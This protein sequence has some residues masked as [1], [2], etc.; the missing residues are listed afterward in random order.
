MPE[1]VRDEIGLEVAGRVGDTPTH[2]RHGDTS[3]HATLSEC[4]HSVYS[5]GYATTPEIIEVAS[6]MFLVVD[7]F[8]DQLKIDPT[9]Q[10]QPRA[11]RVH[12]LPRNV[13]ALS[14]EQC[15][16]EF[17]ERRCDHYLFGW[18]HHVQVKPLSTGHVAFL[19][20]TCGSTV[21]FWPPAPSGR[22]LPILFPIM[23]FRPITRV[24]PHEL[25]HRYAMGTAAITRV[26][27]SQRPHQFMGPAF[28]TRNAEN[29]VQ[30][31]T[32]C[33]LLSRRNAVRASARP[34][35]APLALP[36]ES[37]DARELNGTRLRAIF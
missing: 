27:G 6:G 8:E 33:L 18:R 29:C 34:M 12:F 22:E 30:A 5:V 13:P 36:L 26:G 3:R 35:C 7:I 24:Q 15:T 20:T 2:E 31:A 14:R 25:R 9:K 11:A 4:W 1:I 19:N 21:R 37:A 10:E 16:V 32:Y 28:V 23:R 17:D